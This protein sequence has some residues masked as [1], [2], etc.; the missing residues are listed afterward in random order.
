VGAGHLTV[1]IEIE[2]TGP[3]GAGLVP[4]AARQKGSNARAN[5]PLAD[6]NRAFALDQ[7]RKSYLNTGNI[8]NG[9]EISGYAIKRQPQIPRSWLDRLSTHPIS[10]QCGQGANSSTVKF[11]GM[12][13]F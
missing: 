13:S 2:L 3:Y 10:S 6:F 1:S 12:D 7:G 9:V 11:K 8:C 4:F 5:R